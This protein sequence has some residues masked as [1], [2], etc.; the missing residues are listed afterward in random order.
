MD[1]LD[2]PISPPPARAVG[3]SVP[4]IPQLP[5][6]GTS[7]DRLGQHTRGLVDDVKEWVDLRIKLL[8]T[9]IE[10]QFR[11]KINELMFR[12]I[13]K[14]IPIL[15]TSMGSMF[16]MVALALFI[17]WALGHPAWG[18]LVMGLLFSGVGYGYYWWYQREAPLNPQS[19]HHPGNPDEHES[20][21]G[22]RN[23]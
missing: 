3:P 13:P 17:G 14:L 5:P 12:S 11:G 16:L 21:N 18:F 22:R 4:L 10:N 8:Q 20:D 1:D 6:H 9:E 15:L 23:A 2:T 19:P 7:I